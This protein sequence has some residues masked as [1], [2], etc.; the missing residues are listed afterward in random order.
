VETLDKHFRKL[1]A[2]SFERYG[3]AYAELLT[4]W[5]AIVGEEL[6]RVS[7]PERVR[8]PRRADGSEDQGVPGGGTLIVR[9]VEGR[10]LD[11][12]YMT[13]RIIERINAYYGYAAVSTVKVLQGRLPKQARAPEASAPLRLGEEARQALA[14]KLQSVADDRLRD[15]LERLGTGALAKQDRSRKSPK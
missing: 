15:A 14:D 1:A 4:Q 6:A 10:G 11:L 2:A 7:A 12:Q 8:W 5:P 13:P 3:F 9:A